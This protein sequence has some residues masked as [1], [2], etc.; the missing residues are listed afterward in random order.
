MT[1]EELR[2]EFNALYDMMAASNDINYMRTFG[3][4]HKD[5]MSWM[6]Q[7][8]PDL[9]EEYI[10]KLESIRWKHYLTQRE[11]EKIVMDMRP[12]APWPKEVWRQAM[13]Q[14]G[15]AT[16]YE[17]YYNCYALWVMMNKVYTNSAE[18]IAKIMGVP[19]DEIPSERIIRAVYALALDELCDMDSK[20][21]IRHAYGV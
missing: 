7:N 18:S 4:V 2:N 14:L 3:K 21:S 15:L 6:I 11:A 10:N 1:Q 9:A 19:L 17:P 20:V 13:E 8:K 12:R 16:E 5:M